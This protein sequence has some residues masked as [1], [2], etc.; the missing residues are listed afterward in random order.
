[1]CFWSYPETSE[2]HFHF[3]YVKWALNKDKNMIQT[4]IMY[5]RLIS[6]PPWLIWKALSSLLEYEYIKIFRFLIK[7]SPLNVWRTA[8]FRMMKLLW[9]RNTATGLTTETS[10]EYNI[11]CC[12]LQFYFQTK[13]RNTLLDLLVL[14][15]LYLTSALKPGHPAGQILCTTFLLRARVDLL[16]LPRRA[17]HFREGTKSTE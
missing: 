8:L 11:L 14:E 16:S 9:F 6:M 7:A 3:R 13:T 4:R 15:S 17:A 10:L 1:M 5:F 2:L 12:K